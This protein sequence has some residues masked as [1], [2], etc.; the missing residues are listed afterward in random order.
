MT[1]EKLQEIEAGT[2]EDA[3][4]QLHRDR[5]LLLTEVRELLAENRRLR[6]ALQ[7]LTAA[8][9]DAM[10]SPSEAASWAETGD[11]KGYIDKARRALEPKP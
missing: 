9:N 3:R 10:E 5:R 1:E 6:K 8:I 4:T 7:S 11:M 2:W